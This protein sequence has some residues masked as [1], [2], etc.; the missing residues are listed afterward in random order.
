MSTNA[1]IAKLN[2]DGTVKSIYVH[3]DGYPTHTGKKLIENYE[4]AEKL[5]TLLAI[6]DLSQIEASPDCPEGHTYETSVDGYC[7]A[8]GRDRGEDGADAVISESVKEYN[9][10]QAHQEFNYLFVDGTWF[11]NDNGELEELTPLRATYDHD[12]EDDD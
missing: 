7:V 10:D 12:D 8:Y 5:E 1:N 3:W 11:L 4:T 9:S 2:E 6:G